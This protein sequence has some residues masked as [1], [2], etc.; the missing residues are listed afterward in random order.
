[1]EDRRNTD[2]DRRSR[3]RVERDPRREQLPTWKNTLP[4]G[5]QPVDRRDLERGIERMEMLLGR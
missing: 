1:M 4:P 2:A 3:R 5:N